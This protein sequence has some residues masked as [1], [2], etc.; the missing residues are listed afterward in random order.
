MKRSLWIAWPFPLAVLLTL[1][2]G[3]Q[4]VAKRATAAPASAIDPNAMEEPAAPVPVPVPPPPPLPAKPA[5][6]DKIV[7][8]EATLKFE[9]SKLSPK[10]L[11]AIKKVAEH[12]PSGGGYVLVVTGY[13]PTGMP[14]PRAIVW[15][16]RRADAVAKA[17]IR[18]GFPGNRIMVRGLGAENP[19]A[20]NRTAMGRM[21]NRRVELEFRPPSESD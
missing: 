11:K 3:C 15:S 21:K 7:L 13:T 4:P 20:D 10:G 16:H 8:D 5:L 19:I 17:L 6:P 12:L 18:D 2:A 14:R 9:G 1:G